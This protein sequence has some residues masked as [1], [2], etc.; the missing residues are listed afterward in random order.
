MKSQQQWQQT[1]N[2]VRDLRSLVGNMKALSATSI[3]QYEAALQS[4]DE[5]SRTVDLALTALMSNQRW[6]SE[7]RDTNDSGQRFGAIIF[8]TDQGLCGRFNEAISE[9]ALA[10]MDALKIEP[11]ARRVVAVGARLAE[12]LE[13]AGQSLE[14]TFGLAGSVHAVNDAVSSL[15]VL[16]DHWHRDMHV[17]QAYLFYNQPDERPS[18]QPCAERLLP[19]D[20]H[21]LT[22][23]AAK[24]WPT[25]S[26]P[27]HRLPADLL[28]AALIRQRLFV[29]VYR[30]NVA[31]L[32]AE[33]ASRLRSMQG[34]EKNIEDRLELLIAG[35]QRSRQAAI[36]DE[37]L[38]VI[39]GREALRRQTR[40]GHSAAD[41]TGQRT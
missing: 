40:P 25:L 34:A 23:L 21:V 9:H 16:I 14:A 20:Q 10:T 6:P 13:Q 32:M 22:T 2:T 24:P 35:F 33:H 3:N 12:Y 18:Y 1:I 27:S 7:R 37:I 8:G 29:T 38:E 11:Q 19:I 28:F 15:L 4:L 17:G 5:Y 30:A 31:S 41:W 39:R 36:T 26:R